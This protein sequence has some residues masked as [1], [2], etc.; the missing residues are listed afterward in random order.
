[1]AIRP[2][3]SFISGSEMATRR[4]TLEDQFAFAALSGDKDPLHLDPVAARRTMIG[5]VVVHGVH[6]LFVGAGL[7]GRVSAAGSGFRRLRVNFDRYVQINEE[8]SL[9][10]QEEPGRIVGRLSGEAGITMRITLV[11]SDD[12][13]DSGLAR[14]LRRL[15]PV[16]AMT[17]QRLSIDLANCR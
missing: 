2:K 15:Y 5:A 1:M 3:V 12:T 10:W 13:T 16:R 11:S 14:R 17:W 4:F 6:L 7:V 8:V 9:I